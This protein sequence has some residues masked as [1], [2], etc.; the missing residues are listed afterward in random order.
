MDERITCPF[1]GVSSTEAV[2]IQLHVEENHADNSTPSEKEAVS[3]LNHGNVGAG[4]SMTIEDEWTKCTRP[5]CGEYVHMSDVDEHLEMHA[6]VANVDNVAGVSVTRPLPSSRQQALDKSHAKNNQNSLDRSLKQS[7][8]SLLD[9]FS[10]NSYHGGSR[11]KQFH[12]PRQP[13]R[14]GKH[15]LGPH[16]FEKAMPAEV[17]RRLV[18]GALPRMTNRITSNGRLQQEGIVDN[19]TAGVVPVIG[20]LCA[21]DPSTSMTYLCHPNVKHVHKIQCDGNF[22]GYWNIQMLLSHLQASRRASGIQLLPELL[23]NVLQIQDTIE[24][25]WSDDVCSYGKIETGGI[26]GTRKWIGTSEALAYFTQIGVNA[27]ALCFRD[28]DES[29]GDLAVVSMLDY[30]EAYFMSGLDGAKHHHNSHITQ[31]APMYFQRSGHSMTIIGLERK[32]DGSRNLLL[33]DPSFGTSDGM[34][35]LLAARRM[36]AAPEALLKAYRKSDHTLARWNEFELIV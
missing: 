10:G 14:L 29:S 2:A 1:C 21:L 15:E 30:V 12:G 8:H 9:Y 26:R 20:D 3:D 25:A 19:E 36:T 17:R 6:A 5:G 18:N 32:K 33:Y 34:N 16:A 31:L 23:P 4:Q 27:E 11:P 22:C 28:E 13:G 7:S 24:Q 35:R